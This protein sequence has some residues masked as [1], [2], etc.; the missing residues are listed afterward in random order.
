[1]IID[2][3]FA[4]PVL[5][6]W[7]RNKLLG[8]AEQALS[9]QQ[10]VVNST[11]KGILHYTLQQKRRHTRLKHY[12]PNDRIDLKTGAQYFYHCH[13]ENKKS[14]EHGH[15]HCFIRYKQIPKRVKPKPLSDW[16]KHI[17]NPMTHLVAIAMDRYSQPIRLFTV[18]RWITSEIWYDAH[19]APYF[20]KRFK[21]ALQDDPYWQ[22]L[23]S[24]VEAMLKLFSPQI[25]WL[26]QQRDILMQNHQLKNP[27]INIYDDESLEEISEI[28]ID[29]KQ[30]VEWLLNR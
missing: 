14:R 16:D 22:V 23:D 28:N 13:R 11:S 19:H 3:P 25:I 30:Q 4:L 27:D 20:L 9:A 2:T 29:L 24:W 6:Q 8:F 5:T 10:Q 18:N 15:F 7:Q 21:M 17:H 1:M 26:Q 12:P